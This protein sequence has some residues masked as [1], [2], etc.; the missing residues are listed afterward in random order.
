MVIVSALVAC[1][2]NMI[3]AWAIFYLVA[4]FTDDVPWQY[5]DNDYN[6]ECESLHFPQ[7][8][9]CLMS[10]GLVS[11]STPIPRWVGKGTHLVNSMEN[12]FF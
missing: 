4:S 2:Y 6:T 10:L 9:S 12:A 1:Y 5:C 7:V 8:L 11:A 3:I